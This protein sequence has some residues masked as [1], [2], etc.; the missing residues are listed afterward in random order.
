LLLVALWGSACASNPHAN[1]SFPLTVEQARADLKRMADDPKPLQRPVVIFGGFL[2]LGPAVKYF[3]RKI[4]QYTGDD[5]IDTSTFVFAPSFED[6]RDSA[7]RNTI[8]AFP[9]PDNP[10]EAVEVDVVGISMGGLVGRYA[11]IP[12]QT[13]RRL[14][15]RRLFAIA[16]PHR[17]AKMA[18]PHTPGALVPD[19]RAGSEFLQ[20][21]DAALPQADYQIYSYVRL[22]DGVVGAANAGPVGTHPWWVAHQPFQGGHI[23]AHHDPRIIADIM[24]RLRGEKP[25]ATE[26]PA[27]LPTEEKK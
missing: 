24:R 4:R 21:L 16:T 18:T 14:K 7:M 10:E 15:I 27:P 25:F 9:C 12:D 6:A 17:G 5:R 20:R 13:G 26:P 11:A 3:A 23:S 22:N 2:D 19:M 8:E 1:P